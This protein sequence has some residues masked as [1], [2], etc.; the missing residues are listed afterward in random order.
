MTGAVGPRR[1]GR[2]ARLVAVLVVV[3]VAATLTAVCF[4]K[5]DNLNCSSWRLVFDG[6]GTAACEGQT[7]RLSP[8]PATRPDE[9]HAGLA[10]SSAVSVAQGR[11]TGLEATLRT[12]AQLRRGSSPNP[13]EVAW[14]LW[15]Y[16]DN[17]HFYAVVLKPNGWE[18]SKQ[19]PDYP[20]KQQ[21]LASGSTP[22]FAVGE[23]HR[24]KIRID[25]TSAG[26]MTAV[27]TV[28]GRDLVTVTDTDSPYLRGSVAAYTEDATVDVTVSPATP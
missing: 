17:D 10:I 5:E 28:D 16:Q 22:K 20:G 26:V 21:F 12:R 4:A 23:A 14:L 8:A 6:Y 24:L 15:S 9:T 18:V 25:T 3:A 1:L 7:V 13:W 11:V 2:A 19:N 27:I